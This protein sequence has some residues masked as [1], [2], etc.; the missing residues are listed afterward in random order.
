MKENVAEK[1]SEDLSLVVFVAMMFFAP[2]FIASVWWMLKYLEIQTIT[3]KVL[4][5]WGEMEIIL[6]S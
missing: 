1:L 6:K 4:Y 5:F 3:I 2:G